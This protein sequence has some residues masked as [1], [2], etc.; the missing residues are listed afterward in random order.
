MLTPDVARQ[1]YGAAGKRGQAADS[2][3]SATGTIAFLC[4]NKPI[5]FVAPLNFLRKRTHMQ[6]NKETITVYYT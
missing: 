6:D 1:S 2:V 3:R 4:G 5:A